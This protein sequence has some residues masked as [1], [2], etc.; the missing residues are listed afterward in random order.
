MNIEQASHYRG[1]QWAR[2]QPHIFSEESLQLLGVCFPW[3]E[4]NVSEK[5][6]ENITF[7]LD[8]YHNQSDATNP[9]GYDTSLSGL[10][11]A[12]KAGVQLSNDVIYR[13]FNKTSLN[14]GLELAVVARKGQEVAL[15]QIGQPSV[16]LMREGKV[17]P[18]LLGMDLL[19]SPVNTGHFLPKRLLGQESRC[20]PQLTS[21][22]AEKGDALLFVAHSYA[23]EVIFGMKSKDDRLISELHGQLVKAMPQSPFWISKVPL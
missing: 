20:F 8:S 4:V 3:G 2:P 7:Y 21:F 12:L 23:S 14:S 19:P 1:P 11:N 13:L 10:E 15:V 16:Y 9:F 18:L 5:V 6:Q 17:I 22:R